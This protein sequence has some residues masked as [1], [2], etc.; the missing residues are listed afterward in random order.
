MNWFGAA[1]PVRA[2][3]FQHANLDAVTPPRGHAIFRVQKKGPGN[4][5]CR[6]WCLD[7]SRDLRMIRKHLEFGDALFRIGIGE[8]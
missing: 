7:A 2:G 5:L 6:A 8:G 3:P 4:Q 1:K